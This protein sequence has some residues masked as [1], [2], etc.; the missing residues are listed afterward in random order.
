[1]LFKIGE[2]EVER[3]DHLERQRCQGVPV[4]GPHEQVCMFR[5]N[6][7]MLLVAI[8]YHSRICGWSQAPALAYPPR[9]KLVLILSLPCGKA[10]TN[11]ADYYTKWLRSVAWAL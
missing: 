1:M 9:N 3:G 5:S 10:Y 4:T 2:S 8:S 6:N 11:E 7:G